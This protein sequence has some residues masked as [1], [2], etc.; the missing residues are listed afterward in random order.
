MARFLERAL[1]PG[2]KVG[3]LDLVPWFEED[4]RRRGI[5]FE[6]IGLRAS[7]SDLRSLGIT[8]VVGTDLIEGEY[9]SASGTIWENAFDAPGD[10][11]AKLGSQTLRSRGYPVGELYLFAARVP[12][13]ESASGGQ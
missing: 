9:G 13:E 3:I 6:R 8:H 11:I 5:E 4:L 1:K 12:Q 10:K 7:L 2:D